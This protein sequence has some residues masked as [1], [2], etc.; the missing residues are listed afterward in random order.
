[1]YAAM[2]VIP[3]AAMV[4]PIV[5]VLLAV[6][7]D[8]FFLGWWAFRMWHDEW[9]AKVGDM[10]SRPFRVLWHSSHVPRAR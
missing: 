2:V 7:F 5:L 9:A 10:V 3:L 6:L 1:M 4:V 8:I